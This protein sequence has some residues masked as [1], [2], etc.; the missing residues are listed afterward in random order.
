MTVGHVE[1]LDLAVYLLYRPA[2]AG[3]GEGYALAVVFHPLREAAQPAG[4]VAEIKS[5][6]VYV[7]VDE[8]YLVHLELLVRL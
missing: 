4:A 5:D 6:D 2:G 7:F 3:L 8:C 1:Q